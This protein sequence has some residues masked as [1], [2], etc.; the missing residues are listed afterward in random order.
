MPL[1]N[2]NGSDDEDD[3]DEVVAPR[4][5]Q[6]LSVQTLRVRRMLLWHSLEEIR[7]HQEKTLLLL[8]MDADTEDEEGDDADGNPGAVVDAADEDAASEAPST[9]PQDD[10]DEEEDVV[11]V[12][13]E[14][15]EDDGEQAAAA[16]PDYEDD[17]ETGSEDGGE[18][19]AQAAAVD[20]ALLCR[21]SLRRS[22]NRRPTSLTER[23][24]HGVGATTVCPSPSSGL[25]RTPS[26]SSQSASSS[27]MR[28]SSSPSTWIRCPSSA[29]MASRRCKPRR[30]FLVGL[31]RST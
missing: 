1:F 28:M 16:G 13:E 23:C 14:D 19:G 20:M 2:L 24:V 25:W 6:Q 27:A 11:A 22:I 8:L 4:Q 3:E 15:D 10:D 29:R 7:W 9:Q 30:S 18:G 12:E 5:L 31:S 26:A 17:E 21:S